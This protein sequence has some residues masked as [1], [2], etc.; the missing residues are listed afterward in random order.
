MLALV[1]VFLLAACGSH[2]FDADQ[3]TAAIKSRAEQA[4]AA[5]AQTAASLEKR[6][7]AD[8]GAFETDLASSPVIVLS[9]A[10]LVKQADRGGKLILQPTA[11]NH[12]IPMDERE[13][14]LPILYQERTD[15]EAL[16][17][18]FDLQ[19]LPDRKAVI[20]QA[21][22]THAPIAL[23]PPKRAFKATSMP[24]YSILWP[25]Y[26]GGAYI[27]I[28]SGLA[29]A[30][31]MLDFLMKDAPPLK[32][33]LAFFS[34]HGEDPA[35]DVPVMIWRNGKFV[36]ADQPLGPPPAGAARIERHFTLNGLEWLLV[37]D[38]GEIPSGSPILRP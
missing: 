14:Y 9:W 6:D 38:Y 20:E 4:F 30:D 36:A 25:V 15:G 11:D 32:G 18:G 34:R 21:R 19:A 22:E 33:S 26:R 7:F 3:R 5:V 31:K 10:P 28:V 23:Q 27:G 29:P 35:K 17:L 24:V 16:T 37:F 8:E 1:L 13:D 12:L 2:D